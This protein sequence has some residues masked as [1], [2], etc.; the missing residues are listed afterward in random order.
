VKSQDHSRAILVVSPHAAR[1]ARNIDGARRA[2]ASYGAEIVEELTIH[3][4]EQL[5]SAVTRH[6]ATYVVAAGG[7]GTVGAVADQIANSGTVLVI[8]PLG[9]SNDFAR[10]LR[11]PM[12]VESA[13]TLLRRGKVSTID[14][15][16]LDAPNRVSRRFVHAATVGLNVNFAKLATRASIRRRFGR[17]TY[18]VVAALTLRDVQSFSC[19]LGYGGQTEDL[20]LTQLSVINAP[21]F[22]GFLGLRVR[23]SRSDDGLLDVLAVR[24]LPTRRTILAGLYQL[25]H[26]KRPL[27]GVRALHPGELVVDADEQLDVSLDGEIAGKLP[28]RFAVDG[29]ALRIVTPADFESRGD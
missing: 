3:A 29:K 20:D 24:A 1:V 27:E 26:L 13:A 14:L 16:R 10:S 6:N 5:P 15:G 21:V 8:M 12:N 22:G 18:V 7:D 25:L 4:V 11:I 9:T 19:R 28:C 2:L 17:L 23:G